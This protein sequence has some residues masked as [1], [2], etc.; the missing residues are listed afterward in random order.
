MNSALGSG[1]GW[2]SALLPLAASEDGEHEARRCSW[3]RRER[4][5]GSSPTAGREPALPTRQT[6]IQETIIIIKQNKKAQHQTHP[7][8]PKA[9]VLFVDVCARV[10]SPPAGTY[11]SGPCAGR[12]ASSASPEPLC[13]AKIPPAPL[14][15]CIPSPMLG[16]GKTHLISQGCLATL[17]CDSL[18]PSL[19]IC[20]SKTIIIITVHIL[21]YIFSSFVVCVYI[22]ESRRADKVNAQKGAARS[23]GRSL[24]PARGSLV[25]LLSA[26]SAAG[27]PARRWGEPLFAQGSFGEGGGDIWGG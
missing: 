22:S 5:P 16:K 4:R 3:L 10:P 25:V 8:K 7:A 20:G 11:A 6:D 26:E 24:L 27:L 21:Y 19:F 23:P 2:S 18:L 15:R 13:S 12:A 9:Q 17:S 14:R 1:L